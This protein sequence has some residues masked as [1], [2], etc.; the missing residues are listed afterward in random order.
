MDATEEL[1]SLPSITLF[2]RCWQSQNLQ[3][4]KRRTSITSC[5]MSP[6]PC[7]SRKLYPARFA[8]APGMLLPSMRT[9]RSVAIDPKG[10]MF[11]IIGDRRITRLDCARGAL[12][13]DNPEKTARLLAALKAAVPFKVE[14][15]PSLVTYLRAQHVAIADQTQHIVSNLSYAG[16]EGGIVCHIAPPDKEEALVVSLTQVRVPRSMPLA[17][18]VADYHNHRVKKLKKQT[19]GVIKTRLA[20]RGSRT[21]SAPGGRQG[22][23]GASPLR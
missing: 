22:V 16:D 20:G 8:A 15:V 21:R 13:L 11:P 23:G 2:R 12:M 5:A 4:Q 19:Y 3:S 18:A 14:L 10:G 9:C 7:P 6:R 1:H 17:A